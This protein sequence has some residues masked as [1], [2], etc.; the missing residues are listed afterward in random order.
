MFCIGCCIKIQS[1]YLYFSNEIVIIQLNHQHT[2]LK[3]TRFSLSI[4]AFPLTFAV[5]NFIRLSKPSGLDIQKL[6]AG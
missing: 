2:L 3:K 5:P 1:L 4:Q 6:F